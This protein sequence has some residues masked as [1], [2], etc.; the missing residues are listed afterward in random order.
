[1]AQTAIVESHALAWILEQLIPLF[2][3]GISGIS[4]EAGF[5]SMRQQLSL[6]NGLKAPAK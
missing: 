2:I 5:G 1:M 6:A 4:P 3:S